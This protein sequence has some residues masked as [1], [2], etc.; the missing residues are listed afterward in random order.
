LLIDSKQQEISVNCEN[1]E[2]FIDKGDQLGFT[3]RYFVP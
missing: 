2:A 1:I 3:L